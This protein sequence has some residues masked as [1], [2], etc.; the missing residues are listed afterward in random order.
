MQ[1]LVIA[2]LAVVM[3]ANLYAADS[4]PSSLVGHVIFFDQTLSGRGIGTATFDAQYTYFSNGDPPEPYV[5]EKLGA[6]SFRVINFDPD[7]P[8]IAWSYLLFAF[9]NADSGTIYDE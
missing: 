9:T 6:N 7:N 2:L 1:T 3:A 5:Y 4:A 8:T